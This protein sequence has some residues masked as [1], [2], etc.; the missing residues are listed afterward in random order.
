MVNF[1]T[2]IPDGDSRSPSVLIYLFLLTL[3]FVLQWLTM[4]SE[5]ESDL[6][7]TVDWGRKGHVDFNAGK[8]HHVSFDRSNNTDVFDVKIMKRDGPVLKEK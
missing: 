8:I 2:W 4:A 7:D 5:L 1:P 6:R 3:L